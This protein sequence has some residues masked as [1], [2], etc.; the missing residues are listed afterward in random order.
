MEVKFKQAKD[1]VSEF[2]EIHYDPIGW[3]LHY[4]DARMIIPAFQ[5]VFETDFPV[6]FTDVLLHIRPQDR[7]GM[8]GTHTQF[9]IMGIRPAFVFQMDTVLNCHRLSLHIHFF[10]ISMM[11]IWP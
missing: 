7:G 11:L 5:Q 4:S 1:W 8:A 9:P 6:G 2:T 10:S 3:Q